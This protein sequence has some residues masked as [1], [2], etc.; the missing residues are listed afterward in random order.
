MTSALLLA[1]LL[2]GRPSPRP[3]A[4]ALATA[5]RAMS[6]EQLVAETKRLNAELEFEKLVPFAQELSARANA[7]LEARREAFLLLA[8]ALIILGDPVASEHP[9][10]QLLRI[11]PLFELP[12]WVEPKV[13]LVF[14]KVQAEEREL[15]R[16]LAQRRREAKIAQITLLATTPPDA[17]GGRPLPFTVEVKDPQHDV[18][19]VRVAWRRPGEP[20]YSSLALSLDGER[21]KGELPAEL[22]QSEHGLQ[23]DFYVESADAEGPLALFG[24][25]TSPSVVAIA[26]GKLATPWR[27]PL[28]R[29]AFFSSTA[30]T[31]A[32]GAVTGVLVANQLDQQ[33]RF[34]QYT[35]GDGPISFEVEQ[36]LRAEGA[37]ATTRAN[38]S[39]GISI[40]LAVTTIIIAVLTDWRD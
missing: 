26:P 25:P 40:A 33:R 4:E 24:T 13:A 30:L 7:P 17:V 38:V 36:Q 20:A 5:A 12:R 14:K 1:L 28:P 6:T 31:V 22:T 16:A 32:S 11:D 21:W 29:W 9:F 15:S 23:L 3:A 39:L 34:T 10:T 8:S 2:S 35:A 37:L 27:A 19:T 18:R